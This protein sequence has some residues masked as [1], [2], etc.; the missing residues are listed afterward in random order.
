MSRIW[1]GNGDVVKRGRDE[2]ERERLWAR[3]WAGV[4]LEKT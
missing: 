4:V 2:G 1:V 3:F